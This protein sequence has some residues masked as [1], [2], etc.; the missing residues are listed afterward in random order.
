MQQVVLEE[1]WSEPTRRVIVGFFFLG[2]Q[3]NM[4][5]FVSVG[6]EFHYQAAYH[7][8]TFRQYGPLYDTAT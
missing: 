1:L 5:T 6:Q 7:R 2:D 3:S 4:Y 8:G